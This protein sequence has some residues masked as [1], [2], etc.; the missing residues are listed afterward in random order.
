MY[1]Y[2]SSTA[3]VY[4]KYNNVGYKVT[5]DAN[6][7]VTKTLEKV[8]EPKGKEGTIVKYSADGSATK[9]DWLVLYDNGST[10]DIMSVNTMKKVGDTNGLT[11]GNS[12]LDSAIDSYNSAV[13]TI[14]HYCNDLI[15]NTT[16]QKVRSVGTKFD[17]ADTTATYSSD[18][19]DNWQPT[20]NGRGKVGDINAEDDIIRMSFFD[21]T[22]SQFG[23]AK[24]GNYYWLASRRVDEYSSSV[25]FGVRY[26][27]S[28]GYA[29]GYDILWY[30]GSGS[31][32]GNASCNA[33]RPVVR[34]AVSDVS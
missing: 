17:I 29:G 10:L 1:Q 34:V 3:A 5:A 25:Y 15:T 2:D 14:N 24:S 7:A 4:A 22:D 13:A 30:V 6:T 20:Y 9:T 32:V 19:T 23:Y 18:R 33:V 26:V 11:L 16:K 12:N 21:Q 8:Y 31:A 28:D 27:D